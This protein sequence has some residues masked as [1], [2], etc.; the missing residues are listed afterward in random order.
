VPH[1]ADSP[2][3]AD[4]FD[5]AIQRPAFDRL[6]GRL[7]ARFAETGRL[8]ARGRDFIAFAERFTDS[9][10][11][12]L[13]QLEIRLISPKVVGVSF[14]GKQ[15]RRVLD[16]HVGNLLQNRLGLLLDC[17]AGKVEID[18]IDHCAALVRQVALEPC[19]RLAGRERE[20]YDVTIHLAV[21]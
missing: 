11:A 12:A 15:P 18:P 3:D 17:I 5:A 6:V 19:C 7:R 1:G 21:V 16:H 20:F 8:Q 4:E 14:N 2:A 13:G 9:C 10:R